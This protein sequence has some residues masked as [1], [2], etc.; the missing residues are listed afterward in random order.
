MI[1]VRLQHLMYHYF[2]VDPATGLIV[3]LHVYQTNIGWVDLK[4]IGSGRNN[5]FVYSARKWFREV[6]IPAYEADLIFF[7][8]RKFVEQYSVIEHY[9]FIKDHENIKAELQW[10]LQ[11]T[12]RARINEILKTWVPNLKPNF[13]DECI[14]ALENNSSIVNRVFLGRRMRKIFNLTVTSAIRASIN[15]SIIF[16]TAHFRNRF[17]LKRN[18]RFCFPGG[19]LIAFVGSEASGKSTSTN[20]IYT[21]LEKRFDVSL[22]HLGKPKSS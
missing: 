22:I 2:S 21:W 14:Y 19:K 1:E 15:R 10:L 20:E 3:H 6:K 7:V 4:T 11:R 13:F 5:V 12:D 16:F 8:I 18:N 9:L 17:R